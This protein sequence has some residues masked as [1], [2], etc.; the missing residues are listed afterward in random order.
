MAV[1]PATLSQSTAP[2]SLSLSL[3]F[4]CLFFFP[5]TT[6]LFLFLAL[7]SLTDWLT[8]YVINNC[9]C[10]IKLTTPNKVNILFCSL[11]LLLLLLLNWY[12]E[13]SFFSFLSFF[14]WISLF[15]RVFCFW[16]EGD[17]L[18]LLRSKKE[19]EKE[20]EPIKSE[21]WLAI[22]YSARK[23]QLTAATLLFLPFYFLLFAPVSSKFF[24][25]LLF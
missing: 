7:F 6:P 1:A 17:G 9:V 2:L 3:T 11:L 8:D 4:Q 12:S 10:R 14:L 16:G 15:D 18:F 5:E 22:N 23:D 25:F 13:F 19:K 20:N 24:F 21:P